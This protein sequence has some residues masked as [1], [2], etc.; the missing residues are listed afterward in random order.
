M[1]SPRWSET[2]T[3]GLAPQNRRNASHGRPAA[4]RRALGTQRWKRLRRF[5]LERDGY[6]CQSCG[7]ARVRLLEVHHAVPR[8]AAPDKVFDADN[9]VTRCRPCHRA[10]HMPTVPP[11]VAAWRLELEEN[12][13]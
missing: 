9:C 2:P 12:P 6:R 8:A 4:H 1:N 5:V 11:D 7:C 10:E 13:I 3:L